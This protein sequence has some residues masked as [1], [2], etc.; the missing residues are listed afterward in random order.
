MVRSLEPVL[1]GDI[2][3]GEIDQPSRNKER[4]HPPRSLLGEQQR[5]LFD[6]LQA[7]DA[8]SD[9]DPGADLILIGRWLPSGVG[10]CLLG[11]AH[12]IDNKVIDLAL[13]FRLHPIA[14]VEGA[15]APVATRN[16]TGDL[17]GQI[18][19]VEVVDALGGILSG[20]QPLP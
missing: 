2:A 3:G 18:G 20:G 1:D 17:A 9:H 14:R 16:L 5:G 13:L 10:E 11:S 8:R 12:G 15:V 7:A 4:A 19:D 6:A